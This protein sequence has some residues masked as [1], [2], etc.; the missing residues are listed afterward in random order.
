LHSAVC[1][2]L[3]LPADVLL[4]RN[5]AIPESLDGLQFGRESELEA[6]GHFERKRMDEFIRKAPRRSFLK[7]VVVG[8]VLPITGA[9]AQA[10][11]TVKAELTVLAVPPPPAGYTFF[12]Q[13]EAAFVETM[14][15]VLCPADEFTPNG[16]D[17][18][19][20]A[21]FDRQLS[22]ELGSGA[23]HYMH[24]PWPAGKPQHGYQSPL[25]PGQLFK[26]GIASA[27]EA[28]VSALGKPFDQL[29]PAEA[30][31]FLSE[32]AIGLVQDPRLALASWFNEMV[33]PIFNQACFADPLYGGNGGKVFWRLIGYPGLPATNTINVVRYRGKPYPGSKE[34]K[35]IA[36]FS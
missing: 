3:V 8:G 14:V 27:A 4:R 26:A 21:F 34:P 36:D 9:K 11:Q 33:L 1:L 6:R 29:A 17:C 7:A 20:A 2:S 24:G 28:C 5:L 18:G 10:P 15:N 30:D 35:S 16:V 31:A 13:E 12:S 23:R 25:T 32:L 22:G 19:L